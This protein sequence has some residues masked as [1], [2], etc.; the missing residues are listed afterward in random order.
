MSAKKTFSFLWII[1]LFSFAPVKAENVQEQYYEKKVKVRQLDRKEW[2]KLSKELDYTETWEKKKEKPKEEAEESKSLPSL[3]HF[4]EAFRQIAIVIAFIVVI[5]IIGFLITR[6]MGLNL[7]ANKKITKRDLSVSLEQMEEE[8]HESDLERFLREAIEKKDY[9]LAIRIYYL[10]I[11]KELSVKNYIRWRKEKTNREYLFEM[12]P[13]PGYQKF[14]QL[15]RIFEKAWYGEGAVDE[16][17]YWTLSPVFKEYLE[18]LRVE[19]V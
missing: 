1:L 3:F 13:K 12:S 15:T 2:K 6:M 9:K 10:I 18:S 8:I 14:N 17:H 19:K 16:N 4:S 5:L 7:F 11:L